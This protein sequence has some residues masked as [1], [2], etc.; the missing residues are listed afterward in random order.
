M[1][2]GASLPV[3]DMPLVLGYEEDKYERAVSELVA[4]LKHSLVTLGMAN[5]SEV[6][7]RKV[8]LDRP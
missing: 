8:F 7:L 2:V 6:A 1:L 5:V 4:L 3:T